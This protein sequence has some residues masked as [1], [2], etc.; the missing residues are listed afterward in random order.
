MARH[1]FLGLGSNLGDRAA[2]LAAA[3]E[4]LQADKTI[5]VVQT[6][7]V[8]ETAAYGLQDQP[9][10]LN[11]VLEVATKLVPVLLLETLLRIEN[12]LGR[13]RAQRWG[14]RNIDLD[15]LAYRD[16]EITSERLCV[17]HPEIPKRRFVLE[18]WHEIA[19][20]FMLPKWRR[21]VADLLAQCEDDSKVGLWKATPND[22]EF[23][24]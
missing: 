12:K 7:S 15:L 21:S 23:S 1:I 19:P 4:H 9:A 8:Y 13:V 6:S 20:D 3:R 16:I 17:P 18:P 10:F 14:P 22:L 5:F 2:G 11:Q 24:I